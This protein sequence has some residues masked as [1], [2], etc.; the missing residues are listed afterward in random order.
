MK[1]SESPR[2]GILDCENGSASFYCNDFN[3][4]IM[5]NFVKR[6]GTYYP[7]DTFSLDGQSV[8]SRIDT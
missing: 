8:Y 1:D 5:N 2:S 7:Q 4:Y 3:F 6:E